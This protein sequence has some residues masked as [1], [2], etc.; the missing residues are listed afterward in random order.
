MK[1]KLLIALL[2]V[3]FTSASYAGVMYEEINIFLSSCGNKMTVKSNYPLS[4]EEIVAIS[5]MVEDSCG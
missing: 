2:C 3:L 4:V 5:D 1:K